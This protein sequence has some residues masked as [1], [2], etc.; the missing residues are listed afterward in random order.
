[1]AKALKKDATYADLCAVLERTLE[2][3]R[4]ESRRWSLVADH[5]GNAKVRAEPFDAIELPL[6]ALWL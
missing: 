4:L 2:I 5:G 6:R 1:V 3:L